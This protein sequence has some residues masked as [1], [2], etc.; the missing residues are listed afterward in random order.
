LSYSLPT[1]VF[2]LLSYILFKPKFDKLS[3]YWLTGFAAY[4][5]IHILISTLFGWTFMF[6]VWAVKLF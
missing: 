1:L 6:P 5:A 3:L 4:M 2:L